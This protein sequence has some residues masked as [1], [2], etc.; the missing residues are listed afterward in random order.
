MG[1]RAEIFERSSGRSLPA[2][3]RTFINRFDGGPHFKEAAG[4]D[5]KHTDASQALE[6]RL[7][8]ADELLAP[9]SLDG[10]DL[11]RPFFSAHIL[12]LARMRDA[13][14]LIFDGAAGPVS[15]ERFESMDTVGVGAPANVWQRSEP[16]THL[17]VLDPADGSLRAVPT[18]PPA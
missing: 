11:L 15:P 14:V 5:A 1:D 4:K 10:S 9:Y 18:D 3:Y 8:T 2:T 6:Y 17:L 13:G 16:P 7:L 12:H